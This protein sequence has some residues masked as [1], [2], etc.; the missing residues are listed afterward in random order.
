MTV[1]SLSALSFAPFLLTYRPLLGVSVP[2]GRVLGPPAHQRP[3]LILTSSQMEVWA[4][5]GQVTPASTGL[6][7]WVFPKT[8]LHKVPERHLLQETLQGPTPSRVIWG[9]LCSNGH[10]VELQMGLEAT[11]TVVQWRFEGQ[12]G[13]VFGSVFLKS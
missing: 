1:P 2:P 6:G 8:L 7:G 9:N 12:A 10:F 4:E 11:S 3:D 5:Q 13:L